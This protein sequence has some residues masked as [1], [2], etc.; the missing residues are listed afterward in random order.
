[1]TKRKPAALPEPVAPAAGDD[2]GLPDKSQEKVG[3]EKV[4]FDEEAIR[5]WY[6]WLAQKYLEHEPVVPD[7]GGGAPGDLY[8]L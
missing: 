4:G 3:F 6:K 1:M 8:D 5:A 7:C 2:K